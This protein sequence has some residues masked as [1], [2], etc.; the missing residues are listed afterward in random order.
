MESK[1]LWSVAVLGLLGVLA[2]GVLAYINMGYIEPTTRANINVKFSKVMKE[3][4]DNYRGSMKI[5]TADASTA[6]SL[7]EVRYR[8]SRFLSFSEEELSKEFGEL[9][10]YIQDRIPEG[11]EV[12]ELLLVREEVTGGGCR[13]SEKLSTKSY[14]LV[15]KK[16]PPTPGGLPPGR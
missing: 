8:T 12:G 14:P 11:V 15:V 1:S 5:S 3:L 9:H 16:K 10:R 7:L 13:H 6:G 2:C 4:S